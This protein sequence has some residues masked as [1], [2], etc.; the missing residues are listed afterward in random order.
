MAPM[1]LRPPQAGEFLRQNFGFGSKKSLDV[2]AVRGNGPKFHKTSRARL[3]TPEALTE[4]AL[5]KIGPA[6]VSTSQNVRPEPP[7]R[8]PDR[9]RG[10][11]YKYVDPKTPTDSGQAA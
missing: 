4:W 3:Y 8:D 7:A 10:R 11:P 6:Q 9:P 5:S 1:F 2:L